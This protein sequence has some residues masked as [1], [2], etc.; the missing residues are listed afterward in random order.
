MNLPWSEKRYKKLMYFF[1]NT[2][3]INIRKWPLK[4]TMSNPSEQKGAPIWQWLL[5]TCMFR[6]VSTGAKIFLLT[7]SCRP[8]V[9]PHVLEGLILDGFPWDLT[10]GSFTKI[11]R[12][13]TN[14]VI[15]GHF[16]WRS[17]S[18]TSLAETVS[19]CQFGRPPV[20]PSLRKYQQG[21]NY[22]DL[23][24]I[25]YREILPKPVD[26]FQ[27]SLKSGT[28]HEDLSAFCS[29]RRH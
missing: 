10:L 1:L 25:R 16:T 22:K 27:I 19:D 6:R 4:P 29:C 28:S 24:K 11:C 9:S 12:K 20:L 17:L 23:R 2:S 7:L 21:A 14:L 3:S 26:K 5:I 18:A 8:S 13:I 15:N